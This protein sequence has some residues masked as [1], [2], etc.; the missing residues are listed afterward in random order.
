MVPPSSG[1]EEQ[2]VKPAEPKGLSNK[3][4]ERLK[5]LIKTLPSET[6]P[7]EIAELMLD[8]TE[9]FRTWEKDVQASDDDDLSNDDEP[10]PS[11]PPAMNAS[12]APAPAPASVPLPPSP[13]SILY[14]PSTDHVFYRAKA[15]FSPPPLF[16]PVLFVGWR[17]YTSTLPD[18]KSG[19]KA[20]SNLETV[21]KSTSKSV[22]EDAVCQA[23]SVL[24]ISSR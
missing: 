6:P 21:T 10:L 4:Q 24:N 3:Q 13:T 8:L 12:Y 9:R 22:L 18:D 1:T 7:D 11:I 17:F 5:R 15:V 14:F 16:R 19:R 23:S 20:P 2:Y